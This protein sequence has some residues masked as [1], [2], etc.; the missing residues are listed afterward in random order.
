MRVRLR[1]VKRNFSAFPFSFIPSFIS[2]LCHFFLGRRGRGIE[3][4]PVE[5]IQVIL[6][7]PFFFFLFPSSAGL[8]NAGFMGILSTQYIE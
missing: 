4:A 7:S 1:W 6:R 8:E 5:S 3:V 2:R